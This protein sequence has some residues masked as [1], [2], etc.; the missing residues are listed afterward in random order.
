MTKNILIILIAITLA[1]SPL[2]HPKPVQA[3]VDKDAIIKDILKAAAGAAA[4]ALAKLLV[5]ELEGKAKTEAEDN[6]KTSGMGLVA[7]PSTDA[8]TQANLVATHA[9][10]EVQ[11]QQSFIEWAESFAKTFIQKAVLDVLV[12]QIISYI[13]GNG[14]PQ[15]VTDWK[16]FVEDA[17]QRA[18]GEFAQSLGAGFLCEPF[19][20]Q[21]QIALS[22]KPKTFST[23][24]TC[25]LDKIVGNI[26]NFATDFTN[27]GWIAYGASWQIENNFFGSFINGQEKLGRK[28]EAAALAKLNEAISGGGFLS[29][30]G[31]CQKDVNNPQAAKLDQAA[32]NLEAQASAMQGVNPGVAQ[33]NRNQAA[34][35]RQ[36]AAALRGKELQSTCKLVTPG[37]TLGDLTSKAVGKDIDFLLS[38]DQLGDYV[39]AIL[40]ALLDRVID[41]GLAKANSK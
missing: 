24:A 18:A 39:S 1:F 37:K 2:A 11:K 22:G 12:D 8:K 20:L 17:G 14:K 27:G 35:L 9:T 13:Q 25:T 21:L 3:A 38:A 32:T 31:Q 6:A 15:F 29:A 41:E 5:Q 36:Q 16:G 4:G 19:S 23:E 10:T 33:E 40:D 28:T 26:E 34:S 7:V 30:V